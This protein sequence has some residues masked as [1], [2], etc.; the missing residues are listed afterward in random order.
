MQ[1]PEFRMR[2]AEF[3]DIEHMERFFLVPVAYRNGEYGIVRLLSRQRSVRRL[4]VV[5]SAFRIP[6]SV[7][8]QFPHPDIAVTDQVAVVL[9]LER[10]FPVGLVFRQADVFGGAPDLRVQLDHHAVVKNRYAR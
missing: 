2:N 7:F 10:S 4:H 1:H 9:E 6:Y 5:H 3:Y 8:L